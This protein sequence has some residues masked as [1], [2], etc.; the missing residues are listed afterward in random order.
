L[1]PPD[2][3]IKV[4]PANNALFLMKIAKGEPSNGVGPCQ[5]TYVP[6][7]TI[8]LERGLLPWVPVDNMVFGF[9]IFRQNYLNTGKYFDA[10]G[11]YNGGP[12]WRER[13][14]TDLRS[15]RKR[16]RDARP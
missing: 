13:F 12:R 1:Y 10:A 2:S 3:E 4:T 6:Y 9:G 16:F 14:V 5:I 7:F 11:L 8:M 15:I